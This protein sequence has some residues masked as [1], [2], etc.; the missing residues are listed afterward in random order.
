MVFQKRA[1][2]VVSENLAPLIRPGTLDYA[3]SKSNCHK[4]IRVMSEQ[5]KKK[6][7]YEDLYSV[8]D[9]MIGEIIDGELIV[10]PRPSRKHTY[11]TS[12]LG[13]RVLP[14][15]HFG[16]GGGPGGWIIIIEPEIKLGEHTMVPDLSGWKE[17]RF[18]WEEDQNPISVT[19]DW[20]CEVLSPSTLRLDRIK[21]MAKYADYSVNYLWLIDP[22]Q[23]T[24]EVYRLESGRWLLLDAFDGP[25]KVRVEP[26]EEIEIDLG[27][28][29]PKRE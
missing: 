20:V 6:A 11:A 25:Q 28:L 3:D 26:F 13:S 22:E 24:L 16:E 7:T 5:A 1:C 27:D 21:K 29:W 15:Y 4:R 14:A 18:I 2:I 12:I 9:N 8:P 19:P 23:T 10:T 17:K